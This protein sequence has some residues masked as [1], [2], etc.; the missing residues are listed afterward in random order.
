V[1]RPYGEAHFRR[2]LQTYARYY[3][4]IRTHR[5]LDKDAPAILAEANK[6]S[7]NIKQVLETHAHADHLS[8]A[9][10]QAQDWREG[11]DWRAH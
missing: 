1:R 3:N 8:G 5:S 2:I 6:F 7:V 4:K 9:P 11:S 10:Y